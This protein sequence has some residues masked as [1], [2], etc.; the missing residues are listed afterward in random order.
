MGKTEKIKK[1]LI[2]EL[3]KLTFAELKR[4]LKM[5]SKRRTSS[6]DDAGKDLHIAGDSAGF[7]ALLGAG[8]DLWEN[9]EELDEF[10]QGIYERRKKENQQ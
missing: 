2:D 3:Q 4:L 9:D 1:E 7:D 5:F 10:L 6:P 8:T